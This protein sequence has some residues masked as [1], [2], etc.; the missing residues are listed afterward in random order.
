MV[1]AFHKSFPH[2]YPSGSG[3]YFAAFGA[4][5][6]PGDSTSVVQSSTFVDLFDSHRADKLK[7][8][9]YR[10]ENMGHIAF[11]AQLIYNS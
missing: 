7:L 11:G 1:L 9:N 5:G 4:N 6:Y 2:N 8:S 10:S 3:I